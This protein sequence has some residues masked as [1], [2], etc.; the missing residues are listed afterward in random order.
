MKA[1]DPAIRWVEEPKLGLAGKMYL[2]LIT[3]WFVHDHTASRKPQGDGQLSG[4]RAGNR[5]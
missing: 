5:K 4:R 2:P 3:G 1:T